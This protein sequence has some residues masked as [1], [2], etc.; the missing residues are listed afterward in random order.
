[1]VMDLPQARTSRT[2]RKRS[3]MLEVRSFKKSVACRL[4]ILPVFHYNFGWKD[5]TTPTVQLMLNIVQVVAGHLEAGL[6]IAVHCHAGLGRTGLVIA[7]SLVYSHQMPPDEAV[8]TV[9]LH[10]PGSVQTA[11]QQEFV[12]SFHTYLAKLRL[13]FAA[14]PAERF[15]IATALQRQR[16]WLHGPDR[17]NLRFVPKACFPAFL[18]SRL[19]CY[20]LLVSFRCLVACRLCMKF[21]RDW[22]LWRAQTQAVQVPC[23]VSGTKTFMLLVIPLLS[24]V[25]LSAVALVRLVL[26]RL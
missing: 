19:L 16:E 3:W 12:T 26:V 13:V 24:L 2:N 4:L 10:R 7:C 1:M 8:A 25:P 21:V 20:V 9:R 5:M 18:L 14:H 6:K 22:L 23:S 17:R 15:S 11:R